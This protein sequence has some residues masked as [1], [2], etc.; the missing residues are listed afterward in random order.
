MKFSILSS[1]W[2]S[3]LASNL[4]CHPLYVDWTREHVIPKSVLPISH[5]PRNI[6]PLPKQLNHARGNR[7]YTQESKDGYVTYACTKCVQPG[8]CRG[9][10][11]VTPEGVNPPDTFKGPIA[12]SVLYSAFRYP[13]FAE[14]INDKVLNLDTAI[15][16]DSHFPMTE[17][18]R[19]WIENL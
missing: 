6:I 1:V 14:E 4:P 19:K 9:S 5:N 3:Y 7:P 17:A 18:E 10:A 16:W 2:T 11:L 13:Q 12:R 15:E 8:F